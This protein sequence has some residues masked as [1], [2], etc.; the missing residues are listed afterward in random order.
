MCVCVCVIMWVGEGRVEDWK[1]DKRVVRG[2][3]KG[4]R[5]KGGKLTVKQIN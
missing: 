1:E 5:G 2:K 3:G 4:V